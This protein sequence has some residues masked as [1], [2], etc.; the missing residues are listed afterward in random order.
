MGRQLVTAGSTYMPKLRLV[1]EDD[2]TAE[3]PRHPARPLQDSSDGAF[4]YREL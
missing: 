2:I 1:T 3:V 4:L